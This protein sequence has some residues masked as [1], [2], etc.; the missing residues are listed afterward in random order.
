MKKEI[1]KAYEASKYEDEIYNKWENSGSFNPD[2]LDLPKDA[3]SYTICLPPPNVTGTLHMGHAS[4]LAYQDI[5]IRY[6]RMLGERALWVPGTDHAA[7]ATQTKV[8]KILKE[9]G[10]NRHAMGRDAF[11]EKVKRF[12]KES[13]DTIINQ[14]KKLGSSC[15]WSREAYT[16]DVT[17]TKAVRSVFNMMH[18]DGLIYRG[19]RIVN[20][21]PRCQSTLS[22]DEVEY[23]AQKSI[24]YY[25]KYDSSFPVTIASTRPETKLGDTAVAVHPDDNRYQKYIGQT[26]QVNF[27]GINLYIKIIADKG[28]D[29][30]Y[31]TGALGVTPAHSMADWQLAE[32]ND[33][34]ISKVIDEEG[35][36]REGFK[37]FSGKPVLEAR[38]MV[39]EKLKSA[40]L[41]EKTEEIDNNLSI[42][43]RCDTPIEPLPSLQWFINV[44][45]KIP[46]LDNKTIKEISIDAVKAGVLNRNKINIIPP[47]FE[48]NYFNWMENLRDWCISRQI[49]FG[50]QVPVWYKKLDEEEEITITFFAHE[51][52]DD[53]EQKLASG[54][55][56]SELS[57]DGVKRAK[58]L[59][60]KIK[61]D[62]FHVVFCSDFRRSEETAR[63]AFGARSVKIIKDKRLREC[64]YGIFNR[65][66]AKDINKIMANF[67]DEPYPS[68]ENYRQV[69]N[70]MRE[71]LFDVVNQYPGKKIAIVGHQGP[72]LALDVILKGKSW[73]QA[74]AEDWRN[75]L[76]W[77]AGW[78]YKLNQ[79]NYVGID[80]PN[81]ENWVQ[82]EDTLDTWFS[83]GLWTFSTLAN[84]P[85]QIRIENDKLVIDND[86]YKKFHPT[87]VLETG[88][89][90]LF[91]WVA[92]M[93][94]MTTY[95]MEDIPFENVY[96][97][98]LVLDDKGKKMSKSK[99]NVIDPL[100]MIAKYGADATRLSLVIGSTPGN[101]LRL[102]EEKVAGYRNF[103]N[104]LWNIARFVNT[105]FDI[106]L[107]DISIGEEKLT[108]ADCW[109][110]Q[111]MH[112]LI[113]Q[114][115]KD[116]DDYKFSQ[117]GEKLRDF[118]WNDFADWY[119]EVSKFEKAGEK[120]KMLSLI[121]CD[122]L[123]LWHPFIPF[124]SEVIWQ[125]LGNKDL[126]MINRWPDINKY[127]NIKFEN[128]ASGFV[129]AKSIIESIRNA[130]SENKIEPSKKVKVIIYGHRDK[131]LIKAQAGIIKKLRTGIKTIRIYGRGKKQKNAIYTTVGNIEISIIGGVDKEKELI[132]IKKEIENLQKSI[133][134]IEQKLAN[135]EFIEKAPAEIVKR[136]NDLLVVK[137]IELSNLQNKL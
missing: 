94:I 123:R 32:E 55:F 69:E 3:K 131:E 66:S 132:R 81:A 95:A 102:N 72:Q 29:M 97:H 137:K 113:E 75:K 135:K 40:N 13:H 53:N 18:K 78:E 83:S 101:D 79:L 58:R 51:T 117:A 36:I 17:R 45:R 91:F 4:M 74:I 87:Q 92:R 60:D 112:N 7:I 82:D 24:L 10:T 71:F 6:H 105:S 9:E 46:R 67:I 73:I 42:C 76:Y 63:L 85:N 14:V 57:A 96:L 15:D 23:K 98:G 33:L 99:G 77:R 88:Y 8:E 115:G 56:D 19:E 12:A 127:K 2:N 1:A 103:V 129:L 25:F 38:Q 122:L 90:I 128:N 124:V 50:H 61:D 118:T 133:S 52:T 108:S 47:R 110:M 43:Y 109:I 111:K 39:V 107:S 37:N 114:V 120:T 59:G 119:L 65:R 62:E 22:D 49:W 70:R 41:I 106:Q 93:I 16:L 31:G 5:L 27:L 20:W 84:S 68:G 100:D 11:L 116:L 64:D 28:I 125:E 104:K 34:E 136:E 54:H 89:D 86:D 126:L 30:N 121:L 21:C 26:F 80:T 134:I 35:N 44:N 48:K 130:R